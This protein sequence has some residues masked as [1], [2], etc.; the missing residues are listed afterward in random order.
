MCETWQLQ[1]HTNDLH[2]HT[3]WIH[4]MKI[5]YGE[6]KNLFTSLFACFTSKTTLQTNL[7]LGPKIKYLV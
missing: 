1:L 2:A 7:I 6:K 3:D 4:T 5:Y